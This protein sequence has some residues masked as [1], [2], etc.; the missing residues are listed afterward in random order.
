M[1][2]CHWLIPA[3]TLADRVGFGGHK[4]ISYW[5]GWDTHQCSQ[6]YQRTRQGLIPSCVSCPFL[7]QD[8]S[9]LTAN[10]L[11]IDLWLKALCDR[12]PSKFLWIDARWQDKQVMPVTIKATPAHAHSLSNERGQA[13]EKH[14]QVVTSTTLREAHQRLRCAYNRIPI[15]FHK[16]APGCICIYMYS[17]MHVYVNTT[18]T[19]R[20]I[21]IH[22]YADTNS[23]GAHA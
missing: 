23:T 13:L 4:S 18:Y 22:I 21:C 17:C 20:V 15:A 16:H 9:R 3:S 8:S 19:I 1:H 2:V 14:A 11:C 5:I 10:Q 12:G 7:I 6:G